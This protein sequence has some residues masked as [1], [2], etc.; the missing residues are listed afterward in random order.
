M[1]KI[2]GK[3]PRREPRAFWN[4]LHRYSGLAM[5]LFLGFAAITGCVLCFVRPLDRALNAD[6]FNGPVTV[7]PMLVTEAVDRFQRLHP[8][9]RVRSFPLIVPADQRI[10]VKVEAASKRRPL[11]YDQ[12]FLD[13]ASGAPVGKR[14]SEAAWSRRGAMKALHDVHYTLLVGQWGRWIMAAVAISWLLSNIVGAYLTL[15]LRPPFWKGW[16]RMWRISLKSSLS[17]LLLDLHRSSGLW[18]LVVLTP[19]AFTSVALNLFGEVYEPLVK[20]IVRHQQTAFDRPAPFPQGIDG[21]I[22]FTRAV[23]LA[24]DRLKQ[25]QEKWQ[26]ATA[27]YLPTRNAYG[28]TLTDDATLN[29]RG[30]GPIYWYFDG[31]TGQLVDR[32][33]PYQDNPGLALIRILYPL[34]SGRIIGPIGVGIVF[35]LGLATTE[36][37]ATGIYVWWRK[38]RARGMP[39]IHRRSASKQAS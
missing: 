16:R 38:R 13:R 3:P 30:L 33:D 29:Y 15:P 37:C 27:V 9:L 12:V 4:W 23:A 21:Q 20:A 36:M 22:G 7:R 17:R 31:T 6:L 5:A 19:L 1:Q 8:E 14:S 25:Q 32:D 35:L 24:E 26:P 39:R 28:L 18:L 10:P 34:H 11:G 2:A